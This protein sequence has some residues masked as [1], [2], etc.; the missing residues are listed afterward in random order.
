MFP[1]MA[2]VSLVRYFTWSYFHESIVLDKY[3]VTG[4]IPMDDGRWTWMQ[5]TEKQT[6]TFVFFSFSDVG[7]AF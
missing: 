6:T 5:V 4:E 1:Y 2:R 7:G 3:R